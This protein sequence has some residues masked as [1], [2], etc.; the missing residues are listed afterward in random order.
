MVTAAAA[1]CVAVRQRAWTG[2]TVE[3][4]V[5]TA[6]IAA[7]TPARHP[8]SATS[9]LLLRRRHFV[10]RTTRKINFRHTKGAYI[11]IYRYWPDMVHT[12]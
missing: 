8:G 7:P 5:M 10:R 9:R 6:M 12:I 11:I 4:A 1:A 3:T 2:G